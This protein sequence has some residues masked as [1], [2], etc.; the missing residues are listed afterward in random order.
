MHVG[1]STAP[2][3]SRTRQASRPAIDLYDLPVPFTNSCVNCA[4]TYISETSHSLLSH[5]RALE[6]GWEVI[7]TRRQRCEV[8]AG[9]LARP[10]RLEVNAIDVCDETKS[11][12]RINWSSQIPPQPVIRLHPR[13]HL[14]NFVPPWREMTT[15]EY[16][17]ERIINFFASF[18]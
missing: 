2:I 1:A 3:L 5:H 9:N 15:R 18:P 17:Q 11:V 8:C 14:S 7:D 13:V 6:Y 10:L 12:N 4:S 16:F